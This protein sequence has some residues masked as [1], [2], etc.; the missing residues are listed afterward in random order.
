VANVKLPA[1]Q[2]VRLPVPLEIKNANKQLRN[3]KQKPEGLSRK[4]W[5]FSF[6]KEKK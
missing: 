4:R 6:D 3:N 1:S 5:L 2:L